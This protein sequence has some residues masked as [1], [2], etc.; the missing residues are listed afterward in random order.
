MVVA[1]PTHGSSALKLSQFFRYAEADGQRR[2]QIW[3][4][5]HL[6]LPPHSPWLPLLEQ[7]WVRQHPHPNPALL[8]LSDAED[9]RAADQL[10]GTSRA[11]PRL[12]LLWGSDLRCWGHGA[13]E[14]PAIRVALGESVAQLLA[15]NHRVREPI[16]TLPMALDPEDLPPPSQTTTTPPVLLLAS[17]NPTLGLALQ[18][19][20]SHRGVECRSEL[21]PWPM[22]QWQ[23]AL[24]EACVA[25]VL[26]PTAGEASFGL[27]RLSAMGLRV[28]LVCEQHLTNDPL[29]RDGHNCLL[30]PG[31]PE[32]LADA[33]ASL[34]DRSGAGL[35]RQ[36]VDGGLATLVRHRRARERL[37]FEQL[38]ENHS[39]H[40]QHAYSCH[41]E[42]SS[43]SRAAS[44]THP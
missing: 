44:L 6:K 20:L 3:M 1:A 21:S 8:L 25:V 41:P 5:S 35:R 31:D 7:G 9:W 17:R 32:A 42:P 16:H 2:A 33:V 43:A 11:W 14:R 34:L 27:R 10:Y 15:S 22:Q 36:L 19:N 37:E 26:A 38:L 18:Q 13:L 40:W 23:N 30:R 24:A 39:Q 29:C 28:A 12:H 4:P